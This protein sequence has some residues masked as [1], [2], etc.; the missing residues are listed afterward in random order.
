MRLLLCS[1]RAIGARGPRL[2]NESRSRVAYR[3]APSGLGLSERG[4]TPIGHLQVG[5]WVPRT[6]WA[7][8]RLGSGPF[9]TNPARM[10]PGPFP[11]FVVCF[12][13]ITSCR[14]V[15]LG[16]WF[17]LTGRLA[18]RVSRKGLATFGWSPRRVLLRKY[19]ASVSSSR[20]AQ[21][22]QSCCPGLERT[23]GTQET[24]TPR[25][26]A[27]TGRDGWRHHLRTSR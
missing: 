17:L 16:G 21:L 3:R 22:G 13:A 2:F 20:L 24:P 15:M 19:S 25:V 9:R 26:N 1:L 4:Q 27:A 23:R 5:K 14:G 8:V 10:R 12:R 18:V 7:D 11:P 6:M